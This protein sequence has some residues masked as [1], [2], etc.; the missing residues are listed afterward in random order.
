MKKLTRLHVILIIVLVVI[1]VTTAFSFFSYRAA[2]AKKPEL[3]DEITLAVMQLSAAQEE[4]DLD[5]LRQQLKELETIINNTEPL[6]PEQAPNDEV[7][8]LIVDSTHK[9]TLEHRKLKTEVSAGTETIKADK[10]SEGNKY[11]KAEYDITVKGRLGRINSLIGAIEGA[12]FAT[13]TI[14]DIDI[15]FKEEPEDGR[16]TE[17]WEAEFTIVNLYQYHEE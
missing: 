13:L 16:T 1:V 17:W 12:D 14:E 11:N 8:A 7:L 3:Q 15:E 10:E 6:F 9:F 4:N 5:A 2:E